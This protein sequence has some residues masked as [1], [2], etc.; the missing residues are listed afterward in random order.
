MT[1]QQKIL[2]R[3][4]M[5]IVGRPAGDVGASRRV[6]VCQLQG[7]RL[8]VVPGREESVIQCVSRIC[9]TGCSGGLVTA[10]AGEGRKQLL[11]WRKGNAQ[12]SQPH[13]PAGTSGFHRQLFIERHPGELLCHAVF[14]PRTRDGF[15][16]NASQQI[17]RTCPGPASR[18][19][20]G[21][22]RSVPT[23]VRPGLKSR[24]IRATWPFMKRQ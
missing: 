23:V 13:W 18:P 21:D 2:L 7:D 9:G 4:A 10:F 19:F 3:Q 6:L 20:G 12:P 11:V 14:F 24:P 8:K 15:C 5:V 22:P 1:D 16:H 17:L